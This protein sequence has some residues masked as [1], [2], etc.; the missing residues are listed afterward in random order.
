MIRGS[1]QLAAVCS[2]P[3]PGL[4]SVARSA[5][6]MAPLSVQRSAEPLVQ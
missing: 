6:V 1:V 4:R 5:A 3:G 2:V